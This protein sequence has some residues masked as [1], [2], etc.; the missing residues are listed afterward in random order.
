MEEGLGYQKV[1]SNLNFN[2]ITLF[3]QRTMQFRKCYFQIAR[4]AAQTCG[5][6]N[7]FKENI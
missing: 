4:F 7:N 1:I 6:T 5:Q 2:K 3:G